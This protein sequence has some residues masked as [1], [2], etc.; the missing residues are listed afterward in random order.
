MHR[1]ISWSSCSEPGIECE[2]EREECRLVRIRGQ[3][4]RAQCLNVT[5]PFLYVRA[6]NTSIVSMTIRNGVSDVIAVEPES[7]V[8]LVN[9]L[10]R[11]SVFARDSGTEDPA[12]AASNQVFGS[13]SVF[14]DVPSGNV[15]LVPGTQVPAG[16][17]IEGL[18]RCTTDLDG[19]LRNLTSPTPGAF[20]R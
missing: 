11:V 10:T 13:L 3:L 2:R 20:E 9:N 7:Y 15:R 5:I 17:S 19:K 8:H 12:F 6:S 4:E 1:S 18:G 14:G 16:A